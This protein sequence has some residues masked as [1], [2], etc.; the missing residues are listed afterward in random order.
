MPWSAVR[1]GQSDFLESRF[2]PAG[3]TLK[4]P[5][6]LQMAEAD[7]LLQFWCE[8]QKSKLRPTFEFKGWQNNDK[9]M[10]D[11]V[12]PEVDSDTGRAVSKKRSAGKKI[13]RAAE[14]SSGEDQ[15]EEEGDDNDNDNEDLPLSLPRPQYSRKGG[16]V[17]Q[18][19]PESEPDDVHP[20]PARKSRPA[21]PESEPEEQYTGPTKKSNPPT[22]VE[23]PARRT[24]GPPKKARVQVVELDSEP[25]QQDALPAKKPTTKRG[26]LV[27]PVAK[28]EEQDPPPSRKPTITKR[29]VELVSE[30]EQHSL[31]SAKKS[32]QATAKTG[33]PVEPVTEPEQQAPPPAKKSRPATTRRMF[34]PVE[35]D[36]ESD[37]QEP[38]PP[39]KKFNLPTAVEQPA[40][41][42]SG[43]RVRKLTQ[44]MAEIVAQGTGAKVTGGRPKATGGKTK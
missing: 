1:D 6:K 43:P 37:Q 7:Q 17:E 9:E 44:K 8:R 34:Q 40:A 25:D 21:L 36:S 31:P 2:L 26:H 28:P 27:E 22:M 38:P 33:Q 30:P 4:D 29:P 35:P 13:A 42:P 11:P 12:D 5:S 19:E 20:P 32:K 18:V 39:A 23:Q 3:Q 14:S 16:S 41:G 15:E 10:E 24:W